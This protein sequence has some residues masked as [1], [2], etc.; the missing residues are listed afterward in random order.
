[1]AMN[2][3]DSTIYRHDLVTALGAVVNLYKLN[4]KAVLITGATGTIGSFI[5]DMLLWYNHSCS[6]NIRIYAAG[7]SLERLKARFGELEPD[8]ISYVV[9]DL[10][11]PF[12]FNENADY[13]IHAAGNAY[14]ASFCN[15]ATGTI[16][17]NVYGT[18]NLLKYGYEHGTKRMLLISSGEVYGNI[19]K[20]AVETDNLNIGI[21]GKRYAYPSS[22]QTAEVLCNSFYEQYGMETVVVR[23]CHTLGPV[24]SQNDNR[25]HVQF[26]KQALK[27]EDIVLNS[28]GLNE[29]SYIYIA[30]C[31]SAILTVLLNGKSGDTYNISVSDMYIRIRDLAEI[32]AKLASTSVVYKEPSLNELGERS[33]IMRQVLCSKKLEGLG[34]NGNF[35][36]E[37]GVGH[38]L[39][40]LKDMADSRGEEL[41]K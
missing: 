10:F 6:G 33:H 7:R 35:T 40:I 36:I 21:L 4:N 20:E 22:K 25:A 5:V 26:F 18:Y 1:M 29:R 32:I 41:V 11:S 9:H 14:P 13:I 23:A 16:L 28:K 31:A 3:T 12:E 27:G 30:D 15:D 38:I 34:W 2:Y 19:G 24:F 17:G 39:E 8:G 37:E